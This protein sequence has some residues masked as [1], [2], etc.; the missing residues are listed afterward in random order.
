MALREDHILGLS[1]GGFHRMSYRLL[2]DEGAADCVVCVHG[3]TRNGRDFDAVAE[4]LAAEGW[5]VVVPDVVGR[6]QS[7][8]LAPH[9]AY[10]YPQYLADMAALI[11]RLDRERLAWVGTSM[12]GLIGMMLAAQPKTPLSAL[13][14]ND[15]GPVVPKEALERLALYVGKAPVFADLPAA[16]TYLREVFATFGPL[17]DTQWRY[18]TETSVRPVEA[19]L[20][21]NYDPRL[22]EAF[23]AGPIETVDLRAVWNLVRQPLLLLRGAESDLLSAEQAAE[24]LAGRDDAE[25]LAFEGVG[26]APALLSEDQIAPL[27][28]WLNRHRPS[29]A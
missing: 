22:G 7:D 25:A 15:V 18:L 3:L 1:A 14:M 19:G 21:L 10:G 26:H 29:Q 28:A 17:T 11:A 5:L 9:V 23:T 12:G 27:V 2:G 16:E 6:G 20:T 8:W 24:M 4:R 13:V